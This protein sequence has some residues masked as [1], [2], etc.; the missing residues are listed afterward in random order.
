MGAE[1][2]IILALV[3]A[4]GFFSGAEIAVLAMRNTR[5][6]QLLEDGSTR[7]RAIAVL[8]EQ[9]ERFLATVQI[10]ITVIGATAAAFGGS[11]LA[12][13]LVPAFSR[14]PFIGPERAEQYAFGFVVGVVSFLSLVVG[15]LVPKSLALKFGERY[16]LLVAP[17][18]RLISWI[19]RPLVWALTFVSNLLLKPFGDHTTFTEARLSADEL[20]QLVHEATKTGALSAHAGEIAARAIEFEKLSAA[21]VM[22][23]RNEIVAVPRNA[24]RDELR[25]ILLER[26]HSRMPVYEKDLDHIAGYVAADELLADS[27]HGEP[28]IEKH[29]RPVM[30]VPEVKK[31]TAVLNRLQRER[32]RLAMV[33]DEFGGVSGLVTVEDLVEE[34]VGEIL[35]E[36]EKPEAVL[37]R[38]PDGTCLVLGS[39]PVR[40]V[41]RALSLELPEGDWT[42][43]AGLVI[44]KAGRI[45]QKGERVA[46]EEG[47]VLEVM[48]ATPRLVRL[49]RIHTRAA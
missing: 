24:S 32:Q 13:K 38:E 45:P 10:G 2:A 29:I 11:S 31:A 16:A 36:T 17:A 44:G 43:I 21:D 8:R 28:S 9:P 20:R 27:L 46:L 22:V 26:R 30:M 5:L 48:D 23:P 14:V 4:N 33:V 49:L 42:T 41:S 35:S 15:E 37:K 47:V 6:Q 1:I 12:V 7:A 19:A 18:L 25:T 34:L 40:V 3:V 39:T